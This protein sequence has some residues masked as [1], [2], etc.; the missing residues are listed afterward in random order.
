MYEQRPDLP[1]WVENTT[2]MSLLVGIEPEPAG[3]A[4]LFSSRL[5]N[6]F[7]PSAFVQDTRYQVIRNSSN[8]DN[9][10]SNAIM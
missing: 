8:T 3:S 2:S 6:F 4:L 5:K 1:A 10:S 7:Q 9:W